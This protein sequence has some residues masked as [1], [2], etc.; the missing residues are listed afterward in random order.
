VVPSA[1]EPQR[2]RF[3]S[4]AAFAILALAQPAALIGSRQWPLPQC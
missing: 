4:G 2:G 1:V 3:L